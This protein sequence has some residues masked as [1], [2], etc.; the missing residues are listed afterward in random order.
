MSNSKTWR[1]YISMSRAQS[2]M[3][4]LCNKYIFI[5]GIF[6]LHKDKSTSPAVS[7]SS[8]WSLLSRSWLAY[9]NSTA[10]KFYDISTYDLFNMIPVH[11]GAYIAPLVL[12]SRDSCKPS[13][14]VQSSLFT[15]Y[16]GYNSKSML[17]RIWRPL[18]RPLVNPCA[19]FPRLSTSHFSIS[20]SFATS[21]SMSVFSVLIAGKERD[22]PKTWRL[23]K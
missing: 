18:M 8:A 15:L 6:I 2:T 14:Q 22:K 7:A 19:Q 9:S 23:T 5:Y 13:M 3:F 21:L 11:F 16:F 1:Q 20:C 4:L 12:W 10:Q 17:A